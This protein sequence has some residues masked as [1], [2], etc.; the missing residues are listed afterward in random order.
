MTSLLKIEDALRAA[1]LSLDDAK[2][3]LGAETLSADVEKAGA[4][5]SERCFAGRIEVKKAAPA[6][7]GSVSTV[8]ADGSFSTIASVFNQP[9]PTSSWELLYD[10]GDWMDVVAPGAFDRTLSEKKDG[11]R[12]QM[13][14]NHNRYLDPIGK[15]Q[16]ITVGK[17]GLMADGL[18]ATKI[19]LGAKVYE[20]MLMDAVF[21]SSI[22]FYAMKSEL[23][24]KKKIRTLTDIE[25]LE[26]SPVDIPG[27]PLAVI[28]DVKR[29]G[30]PFN[31]NDIR[32]IEK[33][34]RDGG[35][36]QTEAK[37]A[38]AYLKTLADQ[39]DADNDKAKQ[40]QQAFSNARLILTGK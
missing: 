4:V 3:V 29:G 22:G 9:H 39:R 10:S 32:D 25:L 28:T 31:P 13:Y 26:I 15:W 16:S 30:K 21:G 33:R 40:L 1:G 11:N 6:A 24:E 5:R 2:R 19:E 37:A 36:S 23:D 34:L 12:V 7:D 14:W 20:L 27:D 35:A 18:L 38:I 17:E 8:K